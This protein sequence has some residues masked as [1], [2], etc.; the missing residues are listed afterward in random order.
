M[1]L[2]LGLPESTKLVLDSASLKQPGEVKTIEDYETLAAQNRYDI[3]HLT[4]GRRQ[5]VRL[6]KQQKVIITLPSH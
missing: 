2:L 4:A 3:K 1:N 5:L 6:L